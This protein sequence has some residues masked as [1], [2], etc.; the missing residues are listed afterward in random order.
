M[1]GT[2]K[3]S[4]KE[5]HC[6]GKDKE[7]VNSMCRACNSRGNKGMMARA[8][9][10]FDAIFFSLSFPQMIRFSTIHRVGDHFDV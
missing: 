1:L 2:I 5:L 4:W 7:V 3:P 6:I 9:L 10:S 8:L